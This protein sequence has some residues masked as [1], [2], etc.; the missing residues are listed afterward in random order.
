MLNIFLISIIVLTL[1]AVLTW[2]RL[3]QLAKLSKT[4][5]TNIGITHGKLRQCPNTPNCVCTQY[6]EDKHHFITPIKYE[7]DHSISQVMQL[8]L[9]YVDGER[10]LEI[11]KQ[12]DT[13]LH[14]EAASPTMG[15]RDDLEFLIDEESCLI[16]VRSAARV[17]TSDLGANRNRVELVRNFFKSNISE[18]SFHSEL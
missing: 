12:T 8:L 3:I 10:Y 5:R 1:L 18:L 9:K 15:F 6:P 14:C 13:Y 16:H 2:V 17:G 4:I 11:V 7:E